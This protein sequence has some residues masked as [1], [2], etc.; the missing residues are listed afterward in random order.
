MNHNILAFYSY[1]LLRTTAFIISHTFIPLYLYVDLGYSIFQTSLFITI[2]HGMMIPFI[3]F[4]ERVISKVWVKK[5]IS[6]HIF[7]MALFFYLLQFLSWSFIVDLPL[8]F[9]LACIKSI[10]K[11]FFGTAETVF[12]T[13]EILSNKERDGRNISYI[14]IIYILASILAPI[15]GGIITHT[16]GFLNFFSIIGLLSLISAIPLWIGPD[17][18]IQTN[19][20][21][22]KI[23]NYSFYKLDRN[24]QIWEFGRSFSDGISQ[25]V[26]SIFIILVVHNTLTLWW[27]LSASACIWIVI[28]GIIGRAID[29]NTYTHLVPYMTNFTA[30]IFFIRILFPSPIA[31]LLT[32]SLHKISSPLLKIPFEK[33]LYE[34]IKWFTDRVFWSVIYSFYIESVY[35]LSFLWVSIYF[36]FLEILNIEISY[37][38]FIPIFI[39][40]GLSILLT[41]RITKVVI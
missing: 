16:Y 4:T 15:I 18:Y 35:F 9:L 7:G 19:K 12:I 10:P 36:W 20:R 29:K 37:S 31:L 23:I 13:Q 34:Y 39:I 38:V 32:D 27:I 1:K 3:P 14:Q 22:K 8:I 17:I 41:K 11:A 2:V 30:L 40:Y 33:Y 6:L 21:Y 26:W 5:T 28:S 25:V 24:L